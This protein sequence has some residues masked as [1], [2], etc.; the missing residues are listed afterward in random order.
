MRTF[1]QFV[2]ENLDIKEQMAKELEIP[3]EAIERWAS[4]VA[5]PHPLI[6]SAVWTYLNEQQMKAGGLDH[7]RAE[8][9]V[10]VEDIIRKKD[11]Q[12]LIRMGA[13]ADEYSHEAQDATHHLYLSRT[14]EEYQSALWAVFVCSFDAHSA[15]GIEYYKE[16]AEEIW[17]LR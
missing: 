15:G 5:N 13:P 8:K 6:K 7:L 10:A 1:A 9:I 11:P 4:G 14:L 17:K 2:S 16:M 3:L 12:G